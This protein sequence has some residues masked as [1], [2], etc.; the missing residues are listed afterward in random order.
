M[1]VAGKFCFDDCVAGIDV[2]RSRCENA[3]E[4]RDLAAKAVTDMFDRE[5]GATSWSNNKRQVIETTRAIIAETLE[6]VIQELVT[7]G[8]LT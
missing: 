8:K 6:D 4:L 1:I 2:C 3:R 5:L 7:E